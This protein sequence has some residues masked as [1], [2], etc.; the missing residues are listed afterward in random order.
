MT[1]SRAGA[2][3]PPVMVPGTP[4][5]SRRPFVPLFFGPGFTALH[6][7]A[8]EA[9]RPVLFAVED[10][11]GDAQ[12]PAGFRD[13]FACQEP[14]IEEGSLAIRQELQG[15]REVLPSLPPFHPF[16]RGGGRGGDL[17]QRPRVAAAL[18]LGRPHATRPRS[19]DDIEDAVPGHGQ[20]PALESR[21]AS[22]LE[23]RAPELPNG[24][25]EAFLEEILF[26]PGPI[27]PA[28]GSETGPMRDQPA[29]GRES[30]GQRVAGAV[31]S[32][33][34]G[35]DSP[36]ETGP[37]GRAGAGPDRG[38]QGVFHGRAPWSGVQGR[39]FRRERR[40]PTRSTASRGLL[41]RKISRF[42]GKGGLPGSIPKPDRILPLGHTRTSASFRRCPAAIRIP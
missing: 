19:A 28:E 18:H 32:R 31:L 40:S 26:P 22:E 33:A 10:A 4:N 1:A 30:P 12:D 27:A 11:A 24:G 21:A 29:E 20:D 38:K 5:A 13:R 9:E 34:P 3:S 6:A 39:T 23:R 17:L 41:G 16:G 42:F 25:E 8:Q 35:G 36:R 37:R 14:Q 2:P 7:P 15:P